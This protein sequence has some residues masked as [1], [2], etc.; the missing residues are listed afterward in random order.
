MFPSVEYAQSEWPIKSLALEVSQGF[1]ASAFSVGIGL[2]LALVLR[3]VFSTSRLRD[4]VIGV[5]IIAVI[6][7]VCWLLSPL[8]RAAG[9]LNIPIFLIGFVVAF[10]VMGVPIAFCFGI[11]NFRPAQT[12]T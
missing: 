10:L 4:L 2:M 11:W 7:G 1:R 9:N 12:T 6:G 3:Y 5:V 8:L